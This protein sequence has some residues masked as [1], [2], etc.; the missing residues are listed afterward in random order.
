M[1]IKNNLHKNVAITAPTGIAA[2]NVNGLTVHRLLQLP[3][4]HKQTPKYKPLSDEVLQVLRTD[5]K[6]VELFIIDEVSMISNVTLAYINLRLCEVFDTSDVEDGWFGKKHILVLGD[7][8]QLPPVREKSPFEKL[9]PTEINK[10]I[11]SLSIPNLWTELFSYDELTLNMRQLDDSTFVEMLKRIRVGVTTQSDRDILSNRL[12][13]LLSHSNEGRLMEIAQCLRGLPED[14]VCLLPTRNMCMQLNNAMLKAIPHPEIKLVAKDSLD[15]SKCMITK[16]RACLQKYEDDAS[17]TAG[18][19]ETIIIKE[20]AKVMLRR[21]IDVSLGLVNGSIGV[22]QKVRWDPEDQT[23]PK[24]LVV[25]FANNLIHELLPIKS[26]FEIIP[27]AYVYREQFP[28][29]V[30]YALTIHKSQGLSLK[31]AL[32]D[33]GTS[34]FSCGQAYVALSRVTN[35][36]GVHL[37]N[38]DFKSIKAQASAIT[39][40]NRL[41][42]KYRADLSEIK[43][44]K[45]SKRINNER[46]WAIRK[47]VATVQESEPEK[48]KRKICNNKKTTPKKKKKL[49]NKKI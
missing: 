14:T 23:K 48:K 7:L 39:E 17:M 9:T 11:G 13:P 18:L 10:L 44:S 12:V 41:R 20:G 22:V 3:V 46:E 21:N 1:W 40:Y 32:M 6:T 5:L 4:E 35:L 29:C 33:I 27:R 36:H 28:I 26:K 31:N 34:I 45:P 42:R 25:K 19:E 24:Q 16:A 2:F 38:V 49:S 8:L 15:C 43:S 37:I 47:T 30:A